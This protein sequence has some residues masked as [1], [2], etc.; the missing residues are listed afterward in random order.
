[1][2]DGVTVIPRGEEGGGRDGST[3]SLVEEVFSAGLF[4]DESCVVVSLEQQLF[5]ILAILRRLRYIYV[6]DV[7]KIH[8]YF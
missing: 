7:I 1:M 4:V 8:Q 6:R 2:M 5:S 3:T